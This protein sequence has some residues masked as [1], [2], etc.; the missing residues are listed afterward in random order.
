MDLRGRGGRH[1][2]EHWGDGP[3]GYLGL[4]KAGFANMFMI[5]GPNGPSTNLPA[6]IEAQVDWI[7]E[8]IGPAERNGVRTIEPTQAAEDD[9]TATCDEIANMTLFPK[10]DSWI[11]GANVPGKENAVMFYMAGIG[12]YRQKLGEVAAN[13]YEDFQLSE[14]A[15]NAGV[16]SAPGRRTGPADRPGPSSAGRSGH[17]RRVRGRSA[18]REMPGRTGPGRGSRWTGAGRPRGSGRACARGRRRRRAVAMRSPHRMVTIVEAYPAGSEGVRPP[19]SHPPLLRVAVGTVAVAWARDAPVRGRRRVGRDP[20]AVSAAG[21]VGAP[22]LQA[23][24][25]DPAQRRPGR[26]HAARSGR[27]NGAHRG[28]AGRGADAGGDTRRPRADLPDR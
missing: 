2:N 9:W 28:C 27:G 12:A 8:L 7:G 16:W 23:P 21:V 11:F 17:P 15:E 22:G 6:S 10:A 25:A 20:D 26:R 14:Q 13:G 19:L 24:H 4:S 1:I 5:L 3:T 18:H